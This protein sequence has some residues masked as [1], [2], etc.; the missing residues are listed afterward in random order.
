MKIF[1]LC[2]FLILLFFTGCE[3]SKDSLKIQYEARIV[4]FDPNCETCIVSFTEDLL[5][6]KALAGE[7]P[8]N[9]YQVVNLQK[10][11]FTVGQK[12]KVEVRKAEE[13][14]LPVCKTLD[15]SPAYKN[16]YLLDSRNY[17]DLVLNDTIELGYKDCLNDGN[18]QVYIC[19]DSVISD[20]RCPDGAECVWAGEATTRFK[21]EKYNNEPVYFNLKEGEKD[22]I[23]GG[24]HIA[25][26]KL[27][28]YPTVGSQIKP[29]D[30]KA[31]IVI[32]NF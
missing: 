7:S 6:V 20:S 3:K 23:V 19:F 25:F 9:Y 32:K 11:D 21:I 13:R 22:A 29:G 27:L 10:G 16:L 1:F 28:P 12:L 5:K 31:R 30:Y 2:G 4:G 26:I 24:Y 18:R 17:G 15:A 14:E 8:D